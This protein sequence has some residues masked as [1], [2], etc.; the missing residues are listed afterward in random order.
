MF[1]IVVDIYVYKLASVYYNDSYQSVALSYC[2]VR[3]FGLPILPDDLK[4]NLPI[5][6][7]TV[8]K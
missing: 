6:E 5:S 1:C 4:F 3:T 8:P 7:K 2:L